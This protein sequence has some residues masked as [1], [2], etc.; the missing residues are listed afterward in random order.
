MQ[1]KKKKKKKIILQISK[2]KRDK[3]HKIYEKLEK[4]LYPITAE[5]R[6]YLGSPFFFMSILR[7][8]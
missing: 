1:K 7:L 4:F 3:R 6:G 8:D 5:S 2:R